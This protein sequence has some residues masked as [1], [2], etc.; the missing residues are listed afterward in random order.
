MM[1]VF[2]FAFRNDPENLR[3]R[4]ILPIRIDPNNPSAEASFTMTD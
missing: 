1:P 2:T 4:T 3:S